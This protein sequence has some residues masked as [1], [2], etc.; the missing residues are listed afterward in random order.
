MGTKYFLTVIVFLAATSLVGCRDFSVDEVD[1][2]T[3]EQGGREYDVKVNVPFEMKKGDLVHVEGTDLAVE[4][5]FVLSDSRCPSNVV[6]IH[7]GDAEILLEVSHSDDV[8]LQIQAHIPG[9]VPTPY[10]T[11]NIIQFED[12]RFQLLRLSPYPVN[13]TEDYKESDYVALISI[14]SLFN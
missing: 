12:Y 3:N 8:A 4:F 9:L 10:V 14:T 2:N 1:E 5:Q 7:P 11:N 13:G 6:C